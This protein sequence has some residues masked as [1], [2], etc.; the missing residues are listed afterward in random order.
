MFNRKRSYAG[1]A[2]RSAFAIGLVA[3]TVAACT[4]LSGAPRSGEKL[5]HPFLSTF[6]PEDGEIP[7]WRADEPVFVALDLAEL[8][9][10]INGGAPYYI[11]RGVVDSA[12]CTYVS[13]GGSLLEVQVY[14]AGV[15]K[16]ARDLYEDGMPSGYSPLDLPSGE[17]FIE[18]GTF[19]ALS[20]RIVVGQTFA[21]L[22]VNGM[23][24]AARM[25]LV[26]FASR[27]AQAAAAGG[28][29]K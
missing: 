2:I 1:K 5:P 12:F 14:R 21:L 25:A 19:G 15:E 29:G 7:G 22:W 16:Q 18:K 24:P 26:D 9:S 11:D 20:A 10:R 23:D 3:A 17:G 13:D 6:F 8:T 4:A 27:L 28:K